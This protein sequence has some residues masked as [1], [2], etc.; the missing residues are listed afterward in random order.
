[1]HC[2]QCLL[3]SNTIQQLGE[4]PL[5]LVYHILY[6]MQ[7]AGDLLQFGDLPATQPAT[8]NDDPFAD[9]MNS[10]STT[11]PATSTTESKLEMLNAIGG[12]D[13]NLLNSPEVESLQ[14][15]DEEDDLEGALEEDK[16][17]DAATLPSLGSTVASNLGVAKNLLINQEQ[18]LQFDSPVPTKSVANSHDISASD[19]KPEDEAKQAGKQIPPNVKRLTINC[20]QVNVEP[21]EHEK[22]T[23]VASTSKLLVR[24][25]IFILPV[26]KH[27]TAACGNNDWIH[28]HFNYSWR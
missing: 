8:S 3:E 27:I 11:A 2:L 12:S 23:A 4:V 1:M 18:A 22:I 25:F 19:I 5:I 20:V 21:F 14:G 7:S 28:S 16:D 10:G 15:D 9:L 6:K 13:N 24:S 26:S 17:D